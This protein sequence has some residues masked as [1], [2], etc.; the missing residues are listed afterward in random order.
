MVEGIG[1]LSYASRC[2]YHAAGCMTEFVG[3]QVYACFFAEIRIK[4]PVIIIA[5]LTARTIDKQGLRA[6]VCALRARGL[7]PEMQVPGMYVKHCFD[8]CH[9]VA[10]GQGKV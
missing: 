4:L 8:A 2:R 10:A 1:C 5:D 3:K 7:C 9:G 6:L